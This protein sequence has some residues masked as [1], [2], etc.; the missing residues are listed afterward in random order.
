LFFEEKNMPFVE[1]TEEQEKILAK[2]KFDEYVG[3][4]SK[5]NLEADKLD[6]VACFIN[7]KTFREIC[8]GEILR[9]VITLREIDRELDILRKK[10]GIETPTIHTEL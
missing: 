9:R 1:I 4:R 3:L 2:A 7:S 8:I 6:E 10:L 5:Y